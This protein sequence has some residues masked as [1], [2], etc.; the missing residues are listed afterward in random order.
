M[1]AAFST[2]PIDVVKTRT[3]AQLNQFKIQKL[4]TTQIIKQIIKEEG[5]KGFCKGMVPRLG[6]VAPSCAIMISTYEFL[7]SKF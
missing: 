6:K 7:V 4:S 3:Q 1:I 5:L 2:N